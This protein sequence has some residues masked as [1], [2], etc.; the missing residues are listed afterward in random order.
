MVRGAKTEMTNPHEVQVYYVLPALR[1]DL[2]K[3]LKS[4]GLSQKEIAKLL[5]VRD[6]TISQYNH[7]KRAGKMQFDQ[8]IEAEIQSAARR[9]VEKG[10]SAIQELVYLTQLKDV[11]HMVCEMCGIGDEDSCGLCFRPDATEYLRMR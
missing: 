11:R 4:L 3:Q 7:S 8:A 6:S 9:I 2:S 10:S 1:R 5:G